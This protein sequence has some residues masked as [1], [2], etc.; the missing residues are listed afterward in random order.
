MSLRGLV[1]GSLGEASLAILLASLVGRSLVT[2]CRAFA[3]YVGT[4]LVGDG[5][6]MVW[7]DAFFT[8]N[9]FVARQATYTVLK[10]VISTELVRLMF[11][12]FPGAA[13][14]AK[15]TL[16]T[17]LSLTLFSLV[18]VPYSGG[19]RPVLEDLIPRAGNGALWAMVGLGA[20]A[21]WFF[22]PLHPLHKAILGGFVVWGV[23]FVLF[24]Q[25]LRY[26]DWSLLWLVNWTSGPAYVLLTWYWIWVVWTLEEPDD[27]PRLARLQGAA[28]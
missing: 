12:A 11:G 16:L 22:V 27:A 13:R 17:V 25:L 21:R 20:I 23:P 1:V 2:R 7:P 5:S 10:F 15:A 26:T 28:A 18:F 19:S 8:H 24:N 3:V 6:A 4:V 9:W 14:A